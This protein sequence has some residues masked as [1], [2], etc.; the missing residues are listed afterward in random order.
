MVDEDTALLT[1]MGVRDGPGGHSGRPPPAGCPPSSGRGSR[2][3]HLA[4]D[5]RVQALRD[6][7]VLEHVEALR[8]QAP[9]SARRTRSRGRARG[10]DVVGKAAGVGRTVRPGHRPPSGTVAISSDGGA[11]VTGPITVA[12]LEP[13]TGF[14][15]EDM[16]VGNGSASELQG[17]NA[18]YMATNHACGLGHRGG[19]HRGRG[20]AGRGRQ[21]R[22]RRRCRFSIVADLTPVPALP[23][24][25]AIALA[26]KGSAQA[27]RGAPEPSAGARETDRPN[28]D[29]PRRVAFVDGTLRTEA[30]LTH[31]GA[32]G[33]VSMGV[34]GSWAAGAVLV[35]GD[36][37][38]RFDRVTTGRAAIFTAGR[39]VRLA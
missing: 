16:V 36:E 8:G 20:R 12:F 33:D 19:G 5:Q 11:P 14:E 10:A 38:A 37:P 7:R 35:D 1:A 23:V 29:R 13:V 31:T 25:G 32:D 15:L 21:T 4:A 6:A 3:L 26:L 30:R 17:N 27:P 24:I 22:A 9:G 34:A 18:S 28:A 2:S 39:S